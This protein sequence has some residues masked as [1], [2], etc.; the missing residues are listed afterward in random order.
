LLINRK[1]SERESIIWLIGAIGGLIVSIFPKIL[2]TLAIVVG[3]DYPPSILFL[4]C[5]ITLFLICLYCS[6]QIANLNAQVRE[7]TQS[8]AIRNIEYPECINCKI[9]YKEVELFENCLVKEGNNSG[10]NIG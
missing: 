8:I 7:L 4:G 6:I 5:T 9:K 10:E 2:D 1:F 3:V